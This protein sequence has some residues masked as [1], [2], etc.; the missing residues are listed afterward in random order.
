MPA[1][2]RSARR[3][4]VIPA[5]WPLAVPPSESRRSFILNAINGSLFNFAETL[6]DP[7]LVLV[8][9]VSALTSSN[10]LI[11]AIGTIGAGSWFLPQLF[12]SGWVQSKPRTIV[13][14]RWAASIR[15]A[16]WLVLVASLWW[17]EDRG[18]LLIAFFI[19]YT[20]MKL[21]AGTAG[22]PF[23]E[24]TA[25]TIPPWWR[26]R[27]FATRQLLGGMLG[28]VAGW[29]VKW[30]LGQDGLPF[31]RNYAAIILIAAVAGS[32]ALLI[33]SLIHE[34]PTPNPRPAAPVREQIRRGWAA[35]KED[36][37]FRYFT[38]GRMSLFFGMIA[39]PFFTIVARKVLQ[40][41]PEAAGDYI[42][43]A[44]LTAL[45][46]NYPFGIL[47]DRRGK[48]W[49]MLVAA[50]GWGLTS[51]FALL[52]VITATRGWLTTLPFPAYRLAYPLFFLRGFFTP[53][54]R[55]AG[56]N[57]LLE[58]APERDR[59]LYLGFANTLF[60]L[61]LLLSTVGGKLVDRFG[62]GGIFV[63]S[64]AMNGMAAYFFYRVRKGGPVQAPT[65]T[66]QV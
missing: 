66:A 42:L 23:M 21:M 49:G 17:I 44:T 59:I 24:V 37:D 35:L 34:P 15:I 47:V 48:R 61:V 11:A 19:F 58:L 29:L 26:G 4:E 18:L 46:F 13:I 6:M 14:Y 30:L 62:L 56:Y 63:L 20:V 1:F 41:P 5:N 2:A 25:K 8:W 40:A 16:T 51:L 52:L 45:I 28:L 3:E 57:L 64:L 39:I 54:D 38:L 9:L 27:L 55:L 43:I 32:L 22:L 10:L 65:G 53:F 60:G 33:F 12:L 7:N 50:V 36:L 31:P